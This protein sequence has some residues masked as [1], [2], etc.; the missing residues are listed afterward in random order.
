LFFLES[1]GGLGNQ[2]FVWNLAHV[3]SKEFQSRVVIVYPGKYKDRENHLKELMEFCDHRINVLDHSFFGRLTQIKDRVT[4]SF[5]R[6]KRSID[7]YFRFVEMSSP[8]E[9]ISFSN[10]KNISFVRGFHQSTE[11]VN[12]GFGDFMQ[13]IEEIVNHKLFEVSKRNKEV[14]E[15]LDGC[16]I[17]I[18][19]GDIE[20]SPDKIGVIDYSYYL[21]LIETEEWTK[22]LVVSDSQ[23]HQLDKLMGQ[24][25][26]STYKIDNLTPWEDFALLCTSRNLVIANSTFSWW[27]GKYVAEKGGTVFAPRPWNKTRLFSDSYLYVPEFK[28][29]QAIFARDF[30]LG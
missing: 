11:L 24:R 7:S 15:N 29:K 1:A 27:A 16:A 2:L 6:L 30:G 19:R 22:V 26:I 10:L 13:E 8:E 25:K 3:L 21:D 14:L 4:G 5:P 28:Y 23:S 9:P 12:L 18:R 20:Q 17:H